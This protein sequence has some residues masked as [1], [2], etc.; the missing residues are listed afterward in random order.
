MPLFSFSHPRGPKRTKLIACRSDSAMTTVLQEPMDITN[1]LNNR[2]GTMVH[3]PQHFPGHYTDAHHQLSFVKPEPTM[4]RSA[5]PHTSEHSS[6]SNPHA[7]QRSFH[8]PS[9][10]QAPM[11]IP[12]SMPTNMHVPGFPEM[13]NMGGMPNMTMPPHM[14]Q[15]HD[16][17]QQQQQHHQQQPAKA[18]PCSA[19]GKRFARRSDLSRHGKRHTT[20]YGCEKQKLTN[21]RA[22]S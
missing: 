18:Y 7:M 5:S 15:H 21:S 16:P 14:Q 22:H 11:Q 8:S 10:M 17:H 12:S 20:M 9:A 3:H 19:C 4:E 2:L 1:V 13:P 6:Y